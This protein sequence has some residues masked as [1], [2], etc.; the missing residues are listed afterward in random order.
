MVACYISLCTWEI[1]TTVQTTAQEVHKLLIMFQ[2]GESLEN[3]SKIRMVKRG[4]NTLFK[5]LFHA[6]LSEFSNSTSGK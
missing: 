5:D 6:G 2:H 3:I 1:Q 4:Q